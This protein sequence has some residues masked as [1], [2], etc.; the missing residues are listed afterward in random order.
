MKID[1]GVK[2]VNLEGKVI[3]TEDKKTDIDVGYVLSDILSTRPTS[4]KPIKAM[5]LAQR[6]Y[7]GGL[8]EVDE[9]DF[10]ELREIVEKDEKWVPLVRGQVLKYLASVDKKEEKAEK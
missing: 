3:T 6:L 1:C 8:V 2:I 10:S 5:V 4:F 7:K 9:G